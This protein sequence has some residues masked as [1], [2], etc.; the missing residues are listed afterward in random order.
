MAHATHDSHPT[1]HTET[2]CSGL[3]REATVGLEVPLHRRAQVT[4]HNQCMCA[5]RVSHL[6]TVDVETSL[7]TDI[8]PITQVPV[9]T[10]ER[11]INTWTAE[12]VD[13]LFLAAIQS[14]PLRS[15]ADISAVPQLAEAYAT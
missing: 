3:A 4:S 2:V 8:R 15:A 5:G 6:M 14:P 11:P 7:V 1:H 10:R 12:D 13:R 9:V